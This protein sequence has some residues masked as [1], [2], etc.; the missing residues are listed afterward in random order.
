MD[1][2]REYA[3][4]VDPIL[5]AMQAVVVRYG[6]RA[7]ATTMKAHGYPD[8]GVTWQAG[9]LFVGHFGLVLFAVPILWVTT[10]IYMKNR[11]HTFSKAYKLATGIALLV[12]LVF[13]SSQTAGNPTINIRGTLIES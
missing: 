4:P 12:V 6:I 11:D 3:R 10:T 5:G 7:A 1:T 9:S 13:Y 2:L 8:S